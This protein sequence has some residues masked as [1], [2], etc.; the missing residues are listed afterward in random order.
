MPT[1][2]L[3]L[4]VL[5]KTTYFSQSGSGASFVVERTHG[6]SEPRHAAKAGLFHLPPPVSACSILSMKLG[7]LGGILE[8]R[9]RVKNWA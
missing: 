9:G 4:G 8:S 2:V 5:L 6:S 7:L 3:P 1:I